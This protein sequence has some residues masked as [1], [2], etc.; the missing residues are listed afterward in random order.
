MKRFPHLTRPDRD[1]MYKMFHAMKWAGP[2]LFHHN[3]CIFW[4]TTMEIAKA[5]FQYVACHV[6]CRS[7]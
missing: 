1:A 4:V 7:I 3:V 5:A 2:S 6:Y